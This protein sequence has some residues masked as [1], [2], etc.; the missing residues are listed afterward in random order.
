[1]RIANSTRTIGQGRGRDDCQ[2]SYE[3]IPPM[4]E[5][6]RWLRIRDFLVKRE[7]GLLKHWPQYEVRSGAH[8]ASRELKTRGVADPFLDFRLVFFGV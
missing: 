5:N 1:M 4:S 7:A 6:T 3:D 2:H 8:L